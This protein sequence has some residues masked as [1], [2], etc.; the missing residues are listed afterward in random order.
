MTHKG[1]IRSICL[2]LMFLVTSCGL[3]P[4]TPPAQDSVETATPFFNPA[5]M[6]PTVEETATQAAVEIA[7]KNVQ[8]LTVVNRSPV[9]NAQQLRFSGDGSVLV[10][11]SQITDA[12]NA[13]LFSA[14][15]LSLPDL[16]PKNIYSDQNDRVSDISADGKE[17]AVIS[18]DMNS[19]EVIDISAGNSTVLTMTPG[20]L[21]NNATFS[22]DGANLAVAK[23]E[24]W[25][26]VLYSMSDG[27]EIRTL[28]GFET[29]AP[30][31][32]AGFTQS[33]QWMVWHARA[34]LQLQEIESGV[35]GPTMSHEDF[36]TAYAM[37][38]DGSMLASIA[39]STVNGA[40]VPSVT[41]W[42]AA[43][44]ASLNTLVLNEPAQCLDFSPNGS[45]LAIG[46][47]N[48][49]QLWDVSSG[50]M[51]ASLAQHTGM[52]SALAFSADGKYIA[53]A[54]QDN[55]LFLWQV[56]E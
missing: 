2:V 51:L 24:S 10:I 21:I 44:G 54:G 31:Y 26:V 8:A 53:T 7:A 1:L 33:P 12:N 37:S 39:A 36:V 55:Q 48:A 17:I 23:A 43:D 52:I 30:V 25:E 45:L 47:G 9:A 50:T 42:N 3:Q 13:Q 11:A 49:L 56:S 35:L 28:S 6:N 38:K 18:T 4:V 22:P 29:A 19:L 27:S 14:T 32:N 5:T 15:T 20:Y 46:V 41:L 34:T 16:Q 40:I